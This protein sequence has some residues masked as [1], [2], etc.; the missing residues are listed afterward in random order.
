MGALLYIGL[1]GLDRGKVWQSSFLQACAIQWAMDVVF[2]STVEILWVDFGLP[3]LVYGEVLLRGCMGLLKM[4]EVLLVHVRNERRV[5]RS[6][7]TRSMK[8]QSQ[9]MLVLFSRA[10]ERVACAEVCG[11]IP[12]AMMVKLCAA[13]RGAGEMTDVKYSLLKE[14]RRVKVASDEDSM[15]VRRGRRG[16]DVS[17]RQGED[18]VTLS[19]EPVGRRK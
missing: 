17:L 12:E 6:R 1:K 15:A 11:D 3:G 5:S 9:V 8:M 19:P 7:R 2:V 14:K 4:A 10:M 13:G 16:D 18:V